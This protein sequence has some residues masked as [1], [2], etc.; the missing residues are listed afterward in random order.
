MSQSEL[1]E[2]CGKCGH[3]VTLADLS[4]FMSGW[5]QPTADQKV[6]IN[7]AFQRYHQQHQP[8]AMDEDA[9]RE[10]EM[11]RQ[12]PAILRE[13][14]RKYT[15]TEIAEMMGTSEAVAPI[16]ENC[17]RGEQIDQELVHRFWRWYSIWEIQ[18][19]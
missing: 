15:F 5:K 2:E 10:R 13:L 4:Q 17:A 12:M 3:H 6:A 16:L 11:K 19:E 8:G 14:R 7:A 1:S 18:Q 9:H